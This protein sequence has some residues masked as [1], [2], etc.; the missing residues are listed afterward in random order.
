MLNI[1]QEMFHADLIIWFY[2][3]TNNLN[4]F[5][6]NTTNLKTKNEF[7]KLELFTLREYFQDVKKGMFLDKIALNSLSE[8]YGNIHSAYAYPVI[9]LNGSINIHD[10]L[11]FI[12]PNKTIE[13]TQ[14]PIFLAD[15]V[16]KGWHTHTY[17]DPN[18]ITPHQADHKIKQTSVLN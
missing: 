11:L 18:L 14:N 1:L 12:N 3:G 10:I 7:D 17:L 9:N 5:I 16:I 8:I 13:T 2:P 6:Y 4:E 15:M